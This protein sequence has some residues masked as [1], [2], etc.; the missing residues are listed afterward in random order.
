MKKKFVIVCVILLLL[1]L[2]AG[3]S[4]SVSLADQANS[5]IM[6]ALGRLETAPGDGLTADGDEIAYMGE[7][8]TITKADLER[9][10]RRA[11]LLAEEGTDVDA[12]ALKNIAVREIFCYRAEQEGL[13]FDTED[14]LAWLKDYRSSIEAASNYDDFLLFLD[15]TGMTKE[16]YWAWAQTAPSMQKDYLAT[17][18]AGKIRED[19][20]Q[21][22]SS[23]HGT[24]ENASA[25]VEYYEKYKEQAVEDEQLRPVNG[26][27]K[28]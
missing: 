13:S 2:G 19:F 27:E 18:F 11:A 24:E 1:V 3:F 26:D 17:L 28:E 12:L 6:K 15:G 4:S 9:Y 22:L 25:W 5:S 10:T 21:G 20:D 8:I 14:Y 7:H 16:E 23:P